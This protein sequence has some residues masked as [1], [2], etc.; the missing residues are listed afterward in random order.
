[1]CHELGQMDQVC[2]HCG[3]K[4][5]MEERNS[6]SSHASPILSICCAHGKVLLPRLIEPPSYLLNLYT[7]SE[8]D[9]ISFCKNIR[10]Y[11]NILLC[12]SFG[13]NIEK[14]QGQGVSNFHIHG[15]V[16][17]RIGPLLPEKGHTPAFAQLYIYDSMHENKNYHKIMQ[18]LDENILQNLL[19]MLDECNPYI[20][21][22]CH[23][24][25]LI[26][27]NISNEIFMIIHDDQIRDSHRY[28]TLTASEV[29][30]IMVGDGHELHTANRDILLR[31]RDGDM[32][33]I[34]EIH[35]SYNPLHYVLLF[36]RGDDG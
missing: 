25:D 26:Q 24:R 21:N 13:A 31:M 7:S 12:T 8:P 19:N 1:M 22:F 27:T 10:S 6:S 36:S 23:V 5:W 30:A 32:Q 20:Q 16:Y 17:H 29:T 4:F 11:N 28:N 34:S 9:A 18:K 35:P 33:R 14:F 15:Q 3:A 2:I